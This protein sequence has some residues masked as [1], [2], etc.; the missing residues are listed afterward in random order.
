MMGEKLYYYSD[1]NGNPHILTEEDLPKCPK[2]NGI[3]PSVWIIGDVKETPMV[4]HINCRC[5]M[6]LKE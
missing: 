3:S 2:T 1:E 6:E 5:C 4:K